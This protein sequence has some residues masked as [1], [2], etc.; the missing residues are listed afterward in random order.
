MK[1]CSFKEKNESLIITCQAGVLKSELMKIFKQYKLAPALFL[2]GLPG[3]VAGGVVMN[4]GA[5][6]G[7]KPCEFSEIVQ[8]FKTMSAKGSRTYYNKDI[9]WSYRESSGW[10]KSVIYEVHLKWPLIEESDLNNKI[11]QEIKKRR[12]SQPLNQASCG[13]V[14]K[15]PLPL[16]AGQLIEKAGLKGVQQG[17]AQ[18]SEKHANFIVNLGG[19]SAQDIHKLITLTQ[20]KIYDLFQKRLETEVHYLGSWDK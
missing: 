5:G 20:Q 19:A 8:S 4:A 18:I 12:A 17:K 3:D 1:L 7:L 6:G 11:K 14:F 10:K 13:S 16:F 9:Q 15:N 2:S